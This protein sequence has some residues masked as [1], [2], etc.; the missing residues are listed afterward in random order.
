MHSP[1]ASAD[2]AALTEA[3]DALLPQ[4]Q[5]R[6]CGY[7]AC[8]PYAA[9]IAA[10]DAEI[11]RCPPGG[12]PVIAALARLLERP[13]RPL[14]A[15]V[16]PARAPARVR[17]RAADCI[18]CAKC[19]PACPVDAIVGARKY[20]HSVLEDDCTGCELCIAP[21]PVDCIEL[22]PRP[23]ESAALRAERARRGRERYQARQRRLAHPPE[24]PTPAPAAAPPPADSTRSS[25]A[26][27]A[28]ARARALLAGRPQR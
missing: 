1:A 25:E 17:I 18:G 27:A 21:C 19:L 8:R 6:R 26:E 23:P 15:D 16:G 12:A 13:L 2:P 20:L 11:D 5:C 4:T 3:I 22:Q 10:G 14:A 28:M 24:A 9:A 7:E